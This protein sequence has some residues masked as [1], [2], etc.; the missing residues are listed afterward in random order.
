MAFAIKRVGLI[1]KEPCQLSCSFCAIDKLDRTVKQTVDQ[2]RAI[3]LKLKKLGITDIEQ[4]PILGD[5]LND[6]NLE[7][8]LL[9]CKEHNFTVELHTNLLNYSRLSKI[10]DNADL[11]NTLSVSV[12]VY[13]QEDKEYLDVTGRD[14]YPSYGRQQ[15]V[16]LRQ[17][18]KLKHVTFTVRTDML[19]KY[20]RL[21]RLPNVTVEYS[22]TSGNWGGNKPDQV[23]PLPPTKEGICGA[24][25]YFT[26]IWPNG[27]VS[28]CGCHDI[29]EKH[30]VGNIFKDNIY[31][32]G[33]RIANIT[34]SM[35]KN[36]YPKLCEGCDWFY[37]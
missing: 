2:F 28:F 14:L 3:I 23:N 5:S 35:E 12:S 24:V 4:G 18:S 29:Y 26:G 20:D 15:Q 9:F 36:I 1:Y 10:I 33:G 16:L 27:D 31:G 13:G 25:K 6:P 32:P 34:N 30:V 22:L 21:D 17:L 7:T 8:K 37:D 19:F 11:S